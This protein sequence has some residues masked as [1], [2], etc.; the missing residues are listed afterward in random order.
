MGKRKGE[1]KRVKERKGKRKA[2]RIS[3]VADTAL[4]KIILCAVFKQVVPECACCD[5]L[6]RRN[7]FVVSF[8]LCGKFA[9]LQQA[10]V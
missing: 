9:D 8:E 10:C 1:E 6:E 4:E 2:Y 3:N 5:L 7:G